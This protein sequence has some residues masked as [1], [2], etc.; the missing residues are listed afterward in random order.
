MSKSWHNNG[1][2][3]PPEATEI[4]VG[5]GICYFFDIQILRLSN[6]IYCLVVIFVL[7]MG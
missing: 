4:S 5:V 7:N 2:S 1:P 6:I 3:G